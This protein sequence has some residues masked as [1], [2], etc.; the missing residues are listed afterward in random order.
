[1]IRHQCPCVTGGICLGEQEEEPVDEI[2]PVL[3]VPEYVPSL[4]AA[5]HNMAKN[6]GCI[7]TGLAGHGMMVSGGLRQCQLKY[8][9]TS[10][11]F[12][13]E[14]FHRRKEHLSRMRIGPPLPR[15]F[16]HRQTCFS[17]WS[18]VRRFF[19]SSL[20]ISRCPCRRP[21][22]SLI[23]GSRD[24]VQNGASWSPFPFSQGS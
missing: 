8:L 1:M 16:L 20:R 14:S 18:C 10:L 12:L 19:A 3:C 7:E 6:T 2:I 22:Q 23:A 11:L 17:S 24:Q 13:Q 9:R 15:W 5:D 4:Y 21:L